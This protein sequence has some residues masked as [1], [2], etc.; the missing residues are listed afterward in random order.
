MV[1]IILAIV[2]SNIKPS[3]LRWLKKR[4]EQLEEQNFDPVKAEQFQDAMIRAR[5]KMQ[6]ELEEKALEHQ[7][8]TEEVS[9]SSTTYDIHVHVQCIVYVTVCTCTLYMYM[10]SIHV[11]ACM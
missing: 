9:T 4:E 10:Y 6:R 11:H 5:E 2:W 8:V 3:V 1:V 7:T